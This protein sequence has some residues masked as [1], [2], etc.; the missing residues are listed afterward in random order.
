MSMIYQL[1][2]DY[3]DVQGM[4]LEANQSLE[5]QLHF[6][7]VILQRIWLTLLYLLIHNLKTRITYMMQDCGDKILTPALVHICG[8]PQMPGSYTPHF[9]PGGQ[10]STKADGGRWLYALIPLP[11]VRINPRYVLCCIPELPNGIMHLLVTAVTSHL[12][13]HPSI[14]CLTTPLPQ[15]VWHHLPN[16]HQYP[17]F[18]SHHRILGKSTQNTMTLSVLFYPYCF[19]I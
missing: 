3:N 6:L 11:L 1:I 7:C 8:R 4:V 5:S 15:K 9:H 14:S 18:L 17:N 12:S 2:K 19:R 13:C 16:K 10:P